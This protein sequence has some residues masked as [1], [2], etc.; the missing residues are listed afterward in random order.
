M[1]ARDQTGEY[2][3]AYQ[4]DFASALPAFD[5]PGGKA[6]AASDADNPK[7]PVYGLVQERAIPSRNDVAKSLLQAPVT[8][9]VN[10]VDQEVMP[11]GKDGVR[12]VTLFERPLGEALMSAGGVHPNVTERLIRKQLIPAAISALSTLH[13]RDITHRAIRPNN[14]F[15]A[16]PGDNAIILGECISMPAGSGQLAAFEPLER[17]VADP[18][19][20]GEANETADLFALGAA[21]LTCYLNQWPGYD[22]APEAFLAA[23]IHH[24]SFRALCGKH[25]IPGAMGVMLRGLL[26]DNPAERWNL[27]DLAQWVDGIVPQK[28]SGMKNWSLSKPINFNGKTYADRRHL[29]Q[30][31]AENIVP[32]AAYIREQNFLEWSQQALSHD[33]LSDRMERLINVKPAVELAPNPKADAEMIAKVCMFLD[34]AGPVRYRR[35]AVCFDGLGPAIADAQHRDDRDRMAIFHELLASQLIASVAE[36]ANEKKTIAKSLSYEVS[37]VAELAQHNH[38][39]HGLERALYEVNPSLPCL[40]AKCQ[41]K[42]TATARDALLAADEQAGAGGELS[43][44]FDRHLAA[45]CA[46]KIQGFDR[47]LQAL[48]NPNMTGGQY[49]LALL[50]IMALFQRKLSIPHLPNLSRRFAGALK[51]S[52]KVLKNR[53]RRETLAAKLMRLADSGSL[54]RMVRELDFANQARQDAKEFA[55][56]RQRFAA[57]E[58]E[59]RWL[60]RRILPGEDQSL[61]VGYQAA[62]VIGFLML[63]ATILNY[64]VG[65]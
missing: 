58:N 38:L 18:F 12:L 21:I 44:I 51:P 22:Q 4:V 40:S 65:F 52:I 16:V 20:R 37:R 41:G 33:V 8:N 30:A 63:T 43:T 15:F 27:N 29:A 24:G 64:T 57:I 53:V 61:R 48:A 36:I 23:R 45:F 46:T 13:E 11:A 32:A 31:F 49:A 34:P 60:K 26:N 54:V 14:I 1:A 7:H 39:G 62:A 9:L 59:Q 28:R 5:S 35:V 3:A 25:E 55:V 2:H 17:A 56:A 47:K 19:G 6:Y 42:W 50:D 10:P